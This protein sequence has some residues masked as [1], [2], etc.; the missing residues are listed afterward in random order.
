M[1]RSVLLDGGTGLGDAT[2]SGGAAS[3]TGDR[4]GTRGVRAW[5]A[6]QAGAPRRCRRRPYPFPSLPGRAAYNVRPLFSPS[7]SARAAGCRLLGV[8]DSHSD[9][10]ECWLEAEALRQRGSKDVSFIEETRREST[11]FMH[12]QERNLHGKVFGGYLMRTAYEL[13]FVT[14]N[15]FTGARPEFL[16]SDDIHFLEP[17]EVGSVVVFTSEV[18]F[19]GRTSLQVCVCAEVLD[20]ATGRRRTTNNFHFAFR[21]PPPR[22]LLPRSVWVPPTPHRL[23]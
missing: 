11:H 7:L 8:A 20:P 2:G 13:A 3:A 5:R 9:S 1:R 14:A 18:V 4:G 6:E 12:P 10:H 15:L 19:T 17:V 16:S 23:L 22:R 21:S